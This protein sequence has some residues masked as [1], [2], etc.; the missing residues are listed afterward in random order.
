[1][2]MNIFVMS[3]K[4]KQYIFTCENGFK[5]L[6]CLFKEKNKYKVSVKTLPN[7]PKDCS[8]SCIKFLFRLSFS[9]I[10]LYFFP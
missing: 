1:M 9:L 8:K 5:F 7:R 10:G 2:N 3:I 6:A 4:S